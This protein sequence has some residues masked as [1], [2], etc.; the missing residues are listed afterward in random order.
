MFDDQR[1]CPYTGLRSFT[2][3]ESI[4]FKGREG[5]IDEATA[6][7][8]KNKFLMLTGASG[9][10]KS[11]LVFAGIVPNA[12]SGFLKSQFSNWIVA[13]FRPERDPF[14]NL[15]Q[16]LAEA[17]EIKNEATVSSELR[18]GFSALVDLYKNS[19]FYANKS[20]DEWQ[21][22]SL[23]KQQELQRSSANLIIL[24]DQFEEFFTNPENYSNGVT[25]QDSNLT[26]NLLLETARIAHEYE[27]PIYVVCTMRSDYIGQCAAFRGLPEF[28]GFSQFFV[29]R[30][31]RKQLNEVIEEPAVLSGNSISPRLVERLVYDIT[32]G[33]DQL[34]ILQHALREIWKAAKNG[35]EEM[36][37]LHYA[38]VGGLPPEDLPED[39]LER[40][41]SWFN[42]LPNKIRVCYD[43]HSLGNILNTHAN[44]LYVTAQD[45]CK[46][47][48]G[49]QVSEEDTKHILRNTFVCL[50]KIDHSRAV[51]NR[52][53]LQEI[54]QITDIPGLT[55]D[56]VR[57]V[58]SIYREADNTLIRPFISE[59]GEDRLED[60][61][62]LDITHESLIRN[63]NLLGDWAEQEFE[64]LNTYFEFEQQVDRWLDNGKSSDYLLPIG[65]LT[66]FQGWMDEVEPNKYWINRY[67]E[68]IEDPEKRLAN[69]EY[70]LKNVEE[71]LQRSTRRH[72][73]TRT[74]MKYGFKRI[75]AVLGIIILLT[76][77]SFYGIDQYQRSN[78]VV[79]N[80]VFNESLLIL[81][82]KDIDLFTKVDLTIELIRR[83]QQ[84]YDRVMASLSP[85]DGFYLAQGIAESIV[86]REQRFANPLL[87]SLAAGILM[88][89]L[90]EFDGYLNTSERLKY[91][92][93]VVSVADYTLTFRDSEIFRALE[94]KQSL[95]LLSF[96]KEIIEEDLQVDATELS[97][98]LIILLNS[99]SITDNDKRQLLT[100][101]SPF[102]NPNPSLSESFSVDDL[103]LLTLSGYT[104]NYGALYHV[105]SSYYAYF[106]DTENHLRCIDTLMVNNSG[107]YTNSYFY[108]LT[109]ATNSAVHLLLSNESAFLPFVKS[110][111][112][113]EGISTL[114]FLEKV[115]RKSNTSIWFGSVAVGSEDD[116]WYYD[117]NLDKLSF[118]DLEKIS[119]IYLA[120]LEKLNDQQEKWFKLALHNK[121]MGVY[122][123]D[124]KLRNSV[125]VDYSISDLYFDKAFEYYSKLS[126]RFLDQ[127]IDMPSRAIRT[128]ATRRSLFYYPD[129]VSPE[130]SWDPRYADIPFNNASF[131]KYLAKNNHLTDF[132]SD[133]SMRILL[134]EYAFNYNLIKTGSRPNQSV[135]LFEETPEFFSV[136]AANKFLR[137]KVQGPIILYAKHLFEDGNPKEAVNVLNEMPVDNI[138]QIYTTRQGAF[139]YICLGTVIANLFQNGADSTAHTILNAISKTVNRSSYYAYSGYILAQD[140]Q[141]DKSK[142]LLDSAISLNRRVNESIRPNQV[143]T[144]ATL[145]L[146]NDEQSRKQAMYIW[147]N[148]PGKGFIERFMISSFAQRD[149]FYEAYQLSDPLYPKNRKANQYYS[150]LRGSRLGTSQY[151]DDWQN[152]DRNQ[153]AFEDPLA[154]VID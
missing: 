104:T 88:S 16:A 6:L 28:I 103:V 56:M 134:E 32:E 102:E 17:L 106:G 23:E 13:D 15:T 1:I 21:S 111:C 64:Y 35:E 74:I 52:M 98:A 62:V 117:R 68:S 130:I 77:S 11:S 143:T 25:S 84:N 148:F 151:Q 9:D 86:V 93:N 80:K 75:A 71:F 45:Y 4:Y 12:R 140:G 144:A 112:K 19:K 113:K 44:K 40:F 5:H 63:W 22:A 8:E 83:D 121:L 100:S 10:G 33:V 114:K 55:T 115:I 87:D 105:L 129:H 49:L 126:D 131:I 99:T 145:V 24:A 147:K 110:Y 30:L 43:K 51:R 101:L 107:Y 152:F 66:H 31:N 29:P 123:V 82:S 118:A 20:S 70:K 97:T 141:K 81:A 149:N 108:N 7:L 132:Y 137:S 142:I 3:E 27:L 78:K 60:G 58:T 85:K 119:A 138:E 135:R 26:V 139:L 48:Y 154:P 94:E 14:Q 96:V 54:Q 59:D 136:I 146:Y 2:E 50:T 73:V 120:E 41:N 89:D 79:Y 95:S 53:T 57:K 150:F 42:A 124:H 61:S 65:P 36:D 69:S 37:L 67:N 153:P 125:E 72:A 39:Q 76:L 18:Y 109:D 34:P 46:E 91:H 38:M 90:A 92:N 122:K 127:P 128:G 47:N 116:R 133:Q